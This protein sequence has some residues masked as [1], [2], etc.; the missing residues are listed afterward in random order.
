[1]VSGSYPSL[2][3][4]SSHHF[5]KL[6]CSWFLGMCRRCCLLRLAGVFISAHMGNGPSPLSCG[7]FLSLPLLQAFPNLFAGHVPLLLPSP[8]GLLSGI[9][10]VPLQCSG[11]PTQFATFFLVLLLIIQFFFHFSLGGDR[12][13]QG[14]MLI[15]P[16]IVCGSP[17]CCLAHLVFH[18]FPRYL[19]SGIWQQC[20]IPPG[21]SIKCEVEML[22]AGWRCEGVKVLLLLSGFS[23]KV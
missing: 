7:V 13:V 17:K 1:M 9:S 2:V 18:I 22:C 11:Y 3:E 20:G 15:R 12:Y 23:Y 6:S 10:P 21:F 4:F 5:Y 8:A 14:A 19:A 16:R